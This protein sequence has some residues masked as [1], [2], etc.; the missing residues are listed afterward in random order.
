MNR[1]SKSPMDRDESTF[2]RE[3][4]QIT[5]EAERITP[6][7][8]NGEFNNRTFNNVF[9]HHMKQGSGPAGQR[10]KEP[11]AQMSSRMPLYGSAH[12][13]GQTI[14][15]EDHASPNE[16]DLVY[17]SHR[18]PAN[19]SDS[20]L[21]QCRAKKAPENR[22][23]SKEEVKQRMANYHA[24]AAPAP[25]Q[26]RPP[27]SNASSIGPDDYRFYIGSGSN[28]GSNS[29]SN[30]GST[31]SRSSP[32]ADFSLTQDQDQSHE[33]DIKLLT[34]E[35]QVLQLTQKVKTQERQILQITELLRNIL[36][37]PNRVISLGPTF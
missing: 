34:L 21:Q 7:F 26:L 8:R 1:N 30:S 9:E 33:K 31:G 29:N 12:D 28:S 17:Q 15:Q 22:P 19:Y 20:L 11:S 24:A 5:S 16:L 23:V 13:G 6:M 2:R 35:A 10:M 36:A 25:A 18:N 3:Y 4:S 32:N 37:D 27:I 14:P